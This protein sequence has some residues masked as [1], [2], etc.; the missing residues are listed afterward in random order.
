MYFITLTVLLWVGPMQLRHAAYSCT[1]TNN[2]TAYK[3]HLRIYFAL[4]TIYAALSL[5]MT[6]LL[7]SSSIWGDPYLLVPNGFIAIYYSCLSLKKYA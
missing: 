7:T 4:V 5:V 1:R 2:P 6:P 3:K